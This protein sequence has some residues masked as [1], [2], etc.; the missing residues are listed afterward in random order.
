MTSDGS[1]APLSGV[2]V[3]ELG[4]LIA[5]PFCGQLLADFGADVVKI[6]DPNRSDPMR[7]WGVIEQGKSLSWNVIA[8][9]KRCVCA[10]LRTVEGREFVLRLAAQSDVVVENFRPGTMER[11]G[12]AHEDLERVRPGIILTRV[13]GFG[14]DGPYAHRPGYGSIGEAM[15]GLRHLIGEPDRPPSR[16]G[17]SI[18]D[19]L[20]GMHAALG[21]LLALR[22]R[23]RTGQGQIVDASIFESVLALTESLVSEYAVAGVTRTR[24][25][26]V[27]PGVA[28]SNV[29]TT[30]DG[31]ELLI[32]ANQDTVFR[33]LAD[34]MGRP[35]LGDSAEY[36]THVERGHRQAELDRLINEWAGKHTASTL[37]ALLDE[38]AIPVGR[39][40]VASDMLTDP[41][42]RARRSIVEVKDDILGAVPMQGVAP[43]LSRTPG[44]V[45]WGGP[46]LGEHDAEVRAE[47]ASRSGTP[48]DSGVDAGT[49]D[50][51]MGS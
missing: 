20:T 46:Q 47:L 30:S 39:V 27:L 51:G 38:H 10:D 37:L 21:T 31:Q 28:P 32:A 26:A 42:F 34:A 23:D 48:A 1:S 33:R 40:Y 16:M 7:Q 15:G 49:G 24:S 13:S 3:L 36:G 50:R 9:G 44:S 35:D 8:R 19:L 14:Q 17:V 29:Y 5:G 12:L 41:Q 2:R 11:F 18:G 22:V 43:R 25:G 45:R 6:E 4:Q